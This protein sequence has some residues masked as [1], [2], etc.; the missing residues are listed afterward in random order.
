MLVGVGPARADK[1]WVHTYR[2]LDHGFAKNACKEAKNIGF[3]PGIATCA[4]EFVALQ[5][6]RHKADYDPEARFTRAGALDWVARAEAAIAGLH[7][8]PRADRRAFAVQLLLKK[9][10]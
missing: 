2:A 4:N 6:V 1:A 5:E 8:S 10:P 3:P 9:R 7:A